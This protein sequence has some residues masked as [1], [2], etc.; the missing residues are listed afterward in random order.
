MN[1]HLLSEVAVVWFNVPTV[2]IIP[3]GVQTRNGRSR[4]GMVSEIN[5]TPFV[6]VMLVLLIIFMVTAPMM[7][8]GIDVHLPK[9]NAPSIP[10][11]EERLVVSISED[12]RIFINETPVGSEALSPEL[13][14]LLR[15]FGQERGVI[16]RADRKVDYG[17]VIEVMGVIRQAGIQR[18][19]MVTEPPVGAPQSPSQ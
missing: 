16:L 8:Q 5:V 14:R 18:I 4:R 7:I 10:N 3:M 15:S 19:G 6:D 2:R 11:E 9:T 1:Q 12:R 13:E 17:F